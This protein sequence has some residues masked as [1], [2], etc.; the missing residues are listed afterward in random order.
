MAVEPRSVGE[1]AVSNGAV[2]NDL[3]MIVVNANTAN[4]NNRQITLTNF[5]GNLNVNVA[6]SFHLTTT[7]R[8]TTN[9]LIVNYANTPASNVAVPTSARHIWWDES[10]LYVVANTSSNTIKRVALSNF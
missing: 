9:T 1:L 2:A 10:Y 4:A 5:F 3:V 8:S 7:G 6:G